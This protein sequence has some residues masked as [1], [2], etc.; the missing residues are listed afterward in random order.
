MVSV[1]IYRFYSKN[2]KGHFFTLDEDE[3]DSL[4]NTNPNWRYEGIAF[5][6]F[7]EKGEGMATLH[8]FYSKAYRGHFFTIDEA[9]K[10]NLIANNPNWKYEG[11]AGYVYPE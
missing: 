11:E 10:D 9:E 2:Y 6:A 8:R 5:Y 3:K 1:P 7:G 4:I